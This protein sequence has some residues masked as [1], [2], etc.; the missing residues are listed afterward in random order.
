MTN[1]KVEVIL[2]SRV[3]KRKISKE[4]RKYIDAVK[5]AEKL[6]ELLDEVDLDEIER[7]AEEFRRKF[8]FR[9]FFN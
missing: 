9:G 7:E 6:N 4:V 2:P 3:R 5:A 1:V 8:R